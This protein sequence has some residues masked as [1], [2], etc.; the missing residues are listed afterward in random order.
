ML[1]L[2]KIKKIFVSIESSHCPYQITRVNSNKNI[3]ILKISRPLMGLEIHT[4]KTSVSNTLYLDPR[5][6]LDEVDTLN[7]LTLPLLGLGIK[8]GV[9]E[10]LPVLIIYS[11]EVRPV[12]E[13]RVT[14]FL[15][16]LDV[17]DMGL[18]TPDA[19]V[20]LPATKQFVQVTG[21]HLGGI[22]TEKFQKIQADVEQLTG[23]HIVG[24]NAA[25]ILISGLHQ[26]H[27]QTGR[28]TVIR[29]NILMG[30]STDML[31]VQIDRCV[32]LVSQFLRGLSKFR[33]EISVI[34][35][36]LNHLL[37]TN[38]SLSMGTGGKLMTGCTNTVTGCE[39][40]VNSGHAVVAPLVLVRAGSLNGR[41]PVLFRTGGPDTTT[42]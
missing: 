10:T 25:T 5:L 23:S 7:L 13:A 21:C 15:A 36:E 9:N 12:V 8:G 3:N 34:A 26:A 28:L 41:D 18:N 4:Q 20:V 27:H 42:A 2:I 17:T 31:M 32:D 35:A 38:T 1:V 39:Q 11:R 29:I 19:V 6:G 33:F 30:R 22:F 16:E 37:G 14:G 40:T 24:S